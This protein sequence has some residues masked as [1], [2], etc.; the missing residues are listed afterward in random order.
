M[1]GGEQGVLR[2][3]AVKAPAHAAHEGGDLLPN[4]QKAVRRVR[5]LPHTLDA[6]DDGLLDVVRP[7][8]TQPQ[9]LFGV[10]QTEGFDLYQHPAGPHLRHGH[11]GQPD[12]LRRGETGE[13]DSFHGFGDHGNLL[14]TRW[15]QNSQTQ[16]YMGRF[17]VS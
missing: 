1:V 9:N 14:L 16:N 10:V 5:H 2:I 15:P 3:A 7:D 17:P 13:H 4:R 6:R 12:F 11:L 8:L